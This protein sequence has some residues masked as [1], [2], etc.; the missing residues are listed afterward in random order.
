[1]GIFEY[2]WCDDAEPSP[3]RVSQHTMARITI[4]VGDRIVTS[5]HDR[6]LKDYRDHIFVPLSHVAEWLAVNWWYLWTKPE[7]WRVRSVRGSPPDTIF[8]TLETGSFF[9]D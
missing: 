5:V 6:Y 8:R 1:M 7:A 9:R 4:T 3:D 2:E